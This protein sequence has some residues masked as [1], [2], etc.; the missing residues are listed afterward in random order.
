MTVNK[1]PDILVLCG[2]R[3]VRL[4]PTTDVMPKALVPIKG[5]PIVDYVVNYFLDRRPDKITMCVGYRGQK[6][7]DYVAAT[8]PNVNINFSDAGESASM[9][10]RLYQARTEVSERC[11]VAYGDTFVNIDTSL[12]IETHETSNAEITLVTAK[13]KSPLGLIEVNPDKLVSQFRE[14]PVQ[15]FFIG[16]FVIDRRVLDDLTQEQLEMDD[17]YGLVDLFQQKIANKKMSAYEHQGLNI[18][19]NTHDERKMA[20]QEIINFYTIKDQKEPTS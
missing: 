11:I 1:T 20:E 6:I 15:T 19:F 14:K 12:L 10:Q 9:L 17:G 4:R 16:L 2:G 18:T 5:T 7:R 8:W 13:V 3:G